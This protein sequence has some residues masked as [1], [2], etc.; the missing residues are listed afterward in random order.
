MFARYATALALAVLAVGIAVVMDVLLEGPPTAPVFAAVLAAAWFT[1]F[2]PAIVAASVGTVALDRLSAPAHALWHVDV[3]NMLW[4]LLFLGIVLG[5]AWMVS[6]VR[7][8]DDERG[9]L[10]AREQESRTTTEAVSRAKDD[11]L[12]MISHELRNPLSAIL[13]WIHLLKKMEADSPEVAHA[14]DVIERNTLLQAKL[15]DDLLDVSR[16]VAGKLDIVMQPIDLGGVV[17]HGVRSLEPRARAAGVTV[18]TTIAS[19]LDMLGDEARLEQVVINLVS[20]AIAFTPPN[21]YVY[22]SARPGDHSIELVVRDTGEGIEAATLPQIFDLFHRGPSAAL[23]RREGLGLGL[24]IVKHIVER[25][26]GSIS[27]ESAGPGHGA[28]FVVRL[29]AEVSPP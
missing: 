14:V 4:M 29:P 9:R 12:A 26:G 28:T 10:L 8:M 21:G 18:E 1:G 24:A 5:V 6:T 22:V 11:F 19:G 27:A 15:I 17:R 23:G 25:H 7:R 20:N 16:A 13:G 3:R 2:R